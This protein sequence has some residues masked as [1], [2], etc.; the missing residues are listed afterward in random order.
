MMQSPSTQGKPV[1]YMSKE[2]WEEMVTN[3]QKVGLLPK[4]VKATD[5]YDP[6][7]QPQ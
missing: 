4:E 6:S 3:L 5:L 2:N 7:F 1:G